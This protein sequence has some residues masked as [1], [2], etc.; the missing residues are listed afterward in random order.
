MENTGF[1]MQNVKA[2]D[3]QPDVRGTITI[4][5]KEYELSGWNK[6]S[7]TGSSMS[8]YLLRRKNEI[9][10]LSIWFL[11]FIEHNHTKQSYMTKDV[12]IVDSLMIKHCI[13]YSSDSFEIVFH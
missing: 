6:T 2:N 4:D 1:L 7:R 12:K 8:V 13:P 10:F 5:G 11:V 9:L 3:R